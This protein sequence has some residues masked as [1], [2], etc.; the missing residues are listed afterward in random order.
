[1]LGRRL[2]SLTG[3]ASRTVSYGEGSWHVRALSETGTRMW[4][5]TPARRAAR[6]GPPEEVFGQAETLVEA[7]GKQVAPEAF[8]PVD[9]LREAIGRTPGDAAR[10]NLAVPVPGIVWNA[11]GARSD[12]AEIVLALVANALES[13][14]ERPVV[15]AARN[16]KVGGDAGVRFFVEIEVLDEGAGLAAPGWEIYR[17]FFST[18]KGHRGVGLTMALG[19]AHRNG[20]TLTVE[21]R[22]ER[23]VRACLLFPAVRPG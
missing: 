1:M 16:R 5:F 19:L 13:D 6:Q 4:L 17:P 8:P 3:E 10:I 12:F 23:G 15:V 7:A 2:S 21:N 11:R 9:A 22:P 20:A 18:K 14:P